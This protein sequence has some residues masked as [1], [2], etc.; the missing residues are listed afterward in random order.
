MKPIHKELFSEFL[1]TFILILFGLGVVAMVVVFNGSKGEFISI[2]WAWGFAV[3]FG[4][5][6]GNYSGAHLNPAV[7]I[8]LAAT[9][10]FDW[11]KVPL[12][13]L[14]QIFGAFMAA[15]IVFVNYYFQILKVDPD[16]TK[17][18]GIFTTFPAERGHL[19]MGL[20]DQILGTFLLLFL[21]LCAVDYFKKAKAEHLSPIVIGLIVVAIGMSFGGMFGYAIN[22]ARDFGPRLMTVMVGYSNNGLTDGTF[23]FLVP[24]IGPIIG[25]VLGAFAYDHTVA[26]LNK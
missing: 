26:K 10:R 2:N 1:G 19:I 3:M 5:L 20:F 17:T 16:L 11:K 24:I 15:L 21:I 14:A 7:S 4:I 8:A 6:V 22:P 12:Y 18:A 25:G 13:S 9:N 23:I